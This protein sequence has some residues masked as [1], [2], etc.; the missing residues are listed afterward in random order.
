MKKNGKGKTIVPG[1]RLKVGL[2]ESTE[3]K[4]A[5]PVSSLEFHCAGWCQGFA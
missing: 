4:R 1:V 2:D 3:F 5:M